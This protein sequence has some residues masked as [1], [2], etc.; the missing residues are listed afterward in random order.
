MGSELDEEVG[1]VGTE[2]D[3]EKDL[4]PVQHKAWEASRPRVRAMNEVLGVERT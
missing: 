4:P 2:E 1:V 3:E